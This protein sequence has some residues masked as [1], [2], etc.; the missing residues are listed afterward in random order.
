M[1]RVVVTGI[2]AVSPLGNSLPESWRAAKAGKSGIAPVT[3]CDVSD[4][5][6]KVAGELKGF[7]GSEY[8]SVKERNRLDPFVQYAVAAACMASEDAE[9]VALRPGVHKED[10]Y[11]DYLDSG[12]V[13]IGSSRGGISTL[14]EAVLKQCRSKEEDRTAR[15]SAYLMPATT[16]SMA[17]SYVVL[18]FPVPAHRGQ[19]RSVRRIG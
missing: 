17:S 6:G 18:E 13:I 15:V 9:L 4:L 2:G 1:K 16:I 11:S 3:K 7:D 19:A 12:G 10:D 5:A 14:E 8:L